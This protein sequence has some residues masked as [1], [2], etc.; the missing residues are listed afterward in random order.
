MNK[1]WRCRDCLKISWDEE[2]LHAVSPF[3]DELELTGCPKCR[4]C[5]NGFDLLCE[6]P[7]CDEKVECGW[8]VDNQYHQT[9]YKH[10]YTYWVKP[11][12][13]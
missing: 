13:D 9:C 6:E 12:G 3:D 1:R 4:E 11:V 5:N 7:G 10:Y 8:V 2:L